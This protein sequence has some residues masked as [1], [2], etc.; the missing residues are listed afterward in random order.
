MNT[1]LAQIFKTFIKNNKIYLKNKAARHLPWILVFGASPELTELH[2]LDK[3]L[4]RYELKDIPEGLNFKIAS[5]HYARYFCVDQETLTNKEQL[6]L[7]ISFLKKYHRIFSF[8]SLWMLTEFNSEAYPKISVAHREAIFT[9]LQAFY[10]LPLYFNIFVDP[11]SDKTTASAF[12]SHLFRLNSSENSLEA[13]NQEYDLYL[14]GLLQRLPAE[15][16]QA[17]VYRNV[18]QNI[19]Q[20]EN[21]RQKIYAAALELVAPTPYDPQIHLEGIYLW[22]KNQENNAN[23]LRLTKAKPVRS[24][25][26]K[27]SSWLLI[28]VIICALS[29]WGGW[30]LS[31]KNNLLQLNALQNLIKTDTE[32]NPDLLFQQLTELKSPF[33]N[34]WVPNL[35]LWTG[36]YYAAKVANMDKLILQTN[37]TLWLSA[38]LEDRLQENLTAQD[39]QAL[40]QNFRIYM[41][42]V[43]PDHLNSK[44]AEVYLTDMVNQEFSGDQTKIDLA[45][46]MVKYLMQHSFQP[47]IPNQDLIKQ[48]QSELLNNTTAEDRIYFSMLQNLIL[49]PGNDLQLN[50]QTVPYMSQIFSNTAT[51]PFIA[52]PQAYQQIAAMTK[53]IQDNENDEWLLNIANPLNTLS[54]NIA[55]NI[56]NRFTGNANQ[57][58]LQ[59]LT[60]LNLQQATDATTLQNQF[61]LLAS[62]D[63]PWLKIMTIYNQNTQWDALAQSNKYKW[64]FFKKK[65]NAAPASA[66]AWTTS[67]IQNMQNIQAAYSAYLA[68]PN[69]Q[70]QMAFTDALGALNTNAT[71]PQVIRNW[72]APFS[73]AVSNIMGNQL[74][75]KDLSQIQTL[76]DFY[77]TSLASF[78]PFNLKSSQD[79]SPNDLIKFFG[80]GGMIDTVI[81]TLSD[82]SSAKNKTLQKFI[83]QKNYIQNYLLNQ[84]ALNFTFSILPVNADNDILNSTLTINKTTLVYQH[85]PQQPTL[86][87]WDFSP[88]DYISFSIN[89]LNNKTYQQEFYGPWA[90]FKFLM[91]SCKMNSQKIWACSINKQTVDFKIFDRSGNL[92]DLGALSGK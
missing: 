13:F 65:Q 14:N 76:T 62:A 40:Y 92:L 85:D 73:V 11:S 4:Y 51:I 5:N 69:T 44:L 12:Q 33:Y 74:Q 21:I 28:L 80:A 63:S 90:I 71:L 31:Y 82:S 47:A 46:T 7:L 36:N 15:N 56:L 1:N 48:V 89:D 20:L 23:L 43:H 22:A 18:Y 84:N 54:P 19:F 88:Q 38:N 53:N 35:G 25:H 91:N 75:T 61:N 49:T 81:P 3:D 72:S 29:L 9:V 6:N 34:R 60:N 37:T 78:Y 16:Y 24:H 8:N 39:E 10:P 70:T 77:N 64:D 27:K 41:M 57:L 2:Y 55:Q 86:I 83:R 58:W 30:S 50:D 45:T 67:L 32:L 68:Q 79:V 66:P 42:L 59:A 87:S 52:T 17:E 26:S